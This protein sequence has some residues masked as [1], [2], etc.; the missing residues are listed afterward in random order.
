MSELIEKLT[1][2]VDQVIEGEKPLATCQTAS[3]LGT[4]IAA[5]KNADCRAHEIGYEDETKA[6]LQAIPD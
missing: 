1:K 6:A 5:N 4:A 2:A 3:K